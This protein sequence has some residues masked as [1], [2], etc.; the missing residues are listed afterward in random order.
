MFESLK[1]G[2]IDKLTQTHYENISDS[3]ILMNIVNA[4]D[5]K[6]NLNPQQ[7]QRFVE[8]FNAIKARK[9]EQ[10]INLI[11][12]QHLAFA[13]A[14]EFEWMA[15][16]PYDHICGD[17]REILYVYY[18]TKPS[19]D[20][21]VGEILDDLN[22]IVNTL[23]L[24]NGCDPLKISVM[25]W[26]YYSRVFQNIISANKNFRDNKLA[27]FLFEVSSRKY[28]TSI[29]DRYGESDSIRTYMNQMEEML[30]QAYDNCDTLDKYVE[31]STRS[32]LSLI[33]AGTDMENA[34]KIISWWDDIKN[35]FSKNN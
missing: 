11:Q 30:K 8:Q 28:L 16:V 22:R 14:Y 18:N 26:Q 5:A 20:E 21:T 15:D 9:N 35:I 32:F 31:M 19:F 4:M 13:I 24:A 27:C 10:P 25:S 23:I 17:A 2:R 33:G 1:V 29:L 3:T 34:T 6:K 12:Y 7:Y